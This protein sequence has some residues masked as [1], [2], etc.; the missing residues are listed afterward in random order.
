MN[1]TY[2][3]CSEIDLAKARDLIYKSNMELIKFNTRV[4]IS[5]EQRPM[6]VSIEYYDE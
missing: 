1:D 4:P 6:K 5:D 2:E 3:I